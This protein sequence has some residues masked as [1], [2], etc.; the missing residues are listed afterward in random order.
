MAR[1]P[2]SGD[3]AGQA[4]QRRIVIPDHVSEFYA[5][6]LN[7]GTTPWDFTLFYGSIS[8]P[9]SIGGGSGVAET[10]I[11]IDAVI[12]MSPQHAKAA[13]NAMTQAVDIWED[14]YGEIHI[15]D[16]TLQDGGS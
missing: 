4:G 3:G 6:T 8:L 10:H 7:I 16:Q 12:R 9:E 2:S 1:R 13:A 11:A 15:P 5:N 14:R